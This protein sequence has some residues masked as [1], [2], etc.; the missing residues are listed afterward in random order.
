MP[1]TLIPGRLG[2]RSRKFCQIL[3]KTRER[4]DELVKE[5]EKAVT[6]QTI[7]EVFEICSNGSPKHQMRIKEL[8]AKY[9][10]G[11]FGF[12]DYMALDE[13]YD[14]LGD[15]SRNKENDDE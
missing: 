14:I 1:N 11:E 2:K 10:K 15:V 13:L 4:E 9:E 12:E 3:A 6:V 5:I 7:Q 8:K